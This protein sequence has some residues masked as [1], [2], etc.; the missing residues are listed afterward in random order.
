MLTCEMTLRIL[1]DGYNV[2]APVAAPV[3]APSADW[4]ERERRL[5]LTRLVQHLPE[6]LRSGCCVVFDAAHPPPNV[7]DRFDYDGVQVRFAVGYDEADDLLEELI[8]QHSAPK[9]LAVISS[10]HRVQ[11]AARHRGATV[12]DSQPWLDDLLDDRI[13]LAP[14]RSDRKSQG[15]V[16]NQSDKPS[17]AVDPEQLREWMQEFGFEDS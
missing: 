10:D 8:A 15:A 14:S 9:Q 5:L 4:L 1:I 17:E 11:A 12:F 7:S 3:R 16:E 2:I 6:S 13:G